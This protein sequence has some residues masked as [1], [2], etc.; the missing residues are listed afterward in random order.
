MKKKKK[1]TYWRNRNSRP[2]L[3]LNAHVSINHIFT[4]SPLF[5]SLFRIIYSQSYTE[6]HTDQH[7]FGFQ[8]I[9][10]TCY[11]VHEINF[12]P[13]SPHSYGHHMWTSK[14]LLLP[15]KAPPLTHPVPS[16]PIP[17]HLISS[18]DMTCNYFNIIF[19]FFG[20]LVSQISLPPRRGL[21]S[22][23]AG[24]I[25]PSSILVL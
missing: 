20:S 8:Y 3:I 10:D 7:Y 1:A 23:H 13:F 18:P 22:F 24:I 19:I 25:F 4:D 11:N 9:H 21:P 17:S 5:F 14:K 16:H 15:S 12:T 6:L 2:P